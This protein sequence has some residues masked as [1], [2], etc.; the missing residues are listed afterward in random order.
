MPEQVRRQA[1]NMPGGVLRWF[2]QEA[3]RQMEMASDVDLCEAIGTPRLRRV[4]RGFRATL[5]LEL[6]QTE[7]LMYW[8]P[9]SAPA[10][11]REYRD[12]VRAALNLARSDERGSH[13]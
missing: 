6:D 12:N 3:Q 10:D 11:V 9:D 5:L 8:V 1:L 13:A 7:R 4:G 2:A